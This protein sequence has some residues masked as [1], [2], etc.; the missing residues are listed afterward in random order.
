MILISHRGN[1]N[2]IKPHLENT[3]EYIQAAIDLGYDVEIDVRSV[4]GVLFL[5]HDTPDYEVCIEWLLERK[6]NLWIHC[7]NFDSLSELLSCDLRVFF[8][9]KEE[10]SIIS[11]KFIWAHNLKLTNNKCIIPLLDISDID[12]WLSTNVLGICSDYIQTCRR[13]FCE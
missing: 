12:S 10:Y 6:D 5:G 13:R 1:I 2:T 9:E 7:K 3:K 8:H 11:N 4:D